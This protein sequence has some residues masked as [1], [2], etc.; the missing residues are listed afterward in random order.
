LDAKSKFYTWQNSVTG[1][2]P[3]KMYIY[4]FIYLFR[5]SQFHMQY[6]RNTEDKR[7]KYEI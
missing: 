6:K 2:E 5:N 3:R 7:V 4:L 1:Q